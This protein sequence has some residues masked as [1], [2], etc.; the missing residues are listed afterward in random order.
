MKFDMFVINLMF[1]E[2]ADLDKA[3][4]AQFCIMRKYIAMMFQTD[5]YI[6]ILKLPSFKK[7]KQKQKQ[8]KLQKEQQGDGEVDDQ[9][10]DDEGDAKDKGF[11]TQRQINIQ[12]MLLV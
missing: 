8:K 4:E 12:H 6:R 3:K 1:K 7:Q 9:N 11:T 2:Q 10:D 5:D